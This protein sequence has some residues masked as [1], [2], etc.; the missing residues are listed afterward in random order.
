MVSI[1]IEKEEDITEARRMIRRFLI[2]NR[3]EI[4]P[5]KRMRAL[6]IVSELARNI[7]LYAKTG[8]VTI[9]IIEKDGRKGI[10]MK[11][12]DQGPGISNLEKAMEPKAV[13]KYSV[14]MGLGLLG[15]KRLSDEFEIYT[16]PGI[17]TRIISIVWI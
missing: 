17:G 12:I 10:E 1:K 3:L 7:Y 2:E 6:T 16:R 13:T 9:E 14:G 11:F 8:E 5:L 15:S 4:D